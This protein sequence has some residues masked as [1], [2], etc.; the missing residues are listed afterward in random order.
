MLRII[1]VWDVCKL[2]GSGGTVGNQIV[3]F[4]DG[5]K[6]GIGYNRLTGDV[7]PSPAVVG[8]TSAVTGAAGQQVS[9]DCV[10]IQDVESLHKALGIS[11][12]AGGSYMGFSGSAKVDYV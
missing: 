6:F 1:D 9:S 3:E 11:V 12:D 10:T 4:K 8:S 5:M 2:D 7:L